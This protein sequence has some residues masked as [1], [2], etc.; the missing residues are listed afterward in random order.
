[1]FSFPPEFPFVSGRKADRKPQA[2]AFESEAPAL[3]PQAIPEPPAPPEPL[4]RPE[5]PL[6]RAAAPRADAPKAPQPRAQFAKPASPAPAPISRP[7]RRKIKRDA[8]ATTALLRIDGYHGPP[9]R[10]ELTD[11]TI[12]GARFRCPRPLEIGEK[13]QVRLE[14]GP[15][16]WTTRLRIIHCTRI[17]NDQVSVGCAFLRTELLRPWPAAA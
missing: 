8:L 15:L 3:E 16:R 13:A 17:E 14:V 12:A 5:A 10:I 2:P 1:M 11:I 7:E 9:I 4:P 6:P